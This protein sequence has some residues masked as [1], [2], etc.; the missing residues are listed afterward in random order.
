VRVSY[1]ESDG[2][3]QRSMEDEGG[4]EKVREGGREI[5]SARERERYRVGKREGER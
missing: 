4:R 3:R 2:D 5:G 1:K